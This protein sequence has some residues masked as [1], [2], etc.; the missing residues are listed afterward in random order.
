MSDYMFKSSNPAFKNNAFSGY[1][2]QYEQKMTIEG[3]TNKTLILLAIVVTLSSIIWSLTYSSISNGELPIL[4]PASIAIGS[5]GGIIMCLVVIFSRKENAAY[6]APIYAAFQGLFVG[7]VSSIMEVY[8]P[9][10]V[11]QAVLLTFGVF[12][13][14]LIIYKMNWIPVTQTL[15]IGIYCAVGS[16]ALVYI[17]SLIMRLLGSGIPFIHS[18][19]PIGI[20]F[21]VLVCGIAAVCFLLDFDFIEKRVEAGS[22][23]YLE[24]YAA[25]GLLV[26][27]VWLYIE[28]LH[29]LAKLRD[30]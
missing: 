14:M 28:I 11:L 16:I 13:A 24:W 10:I 27:L 2:R 26:T 18:S 17:I 19:G 30:R 7:G 25:F 22:P 3:T 9:N 12:F 5:I 4:I 6:M 8:Y 20:G 21:S 23:K 29:L 1:G 15:R